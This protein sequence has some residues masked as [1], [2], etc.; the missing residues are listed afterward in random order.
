MAMPNKKKLNKWKDTSLRHKFHVVRKA[1][2]RIILY[3]VLF[4]LAFVFLYPFIKMITTALKSD[5]DIQN[6]TIKWIP[7]SLDWSSFVSAF[8]M[9]KYPK[10]FMN[11]FLVTGFATI[12]HILGC[13]FIGYGFARYKFRGKGLLF[14]GVILSMLIPEQLLSSS[15][16]I[17]FSRVG[18][19]DTYLPFIVPAFLGFGLKGG[20]FV[21]LFR[22]FFIGMPYEMEEAARI[23]GCGPL[24]IFGWIMVPMARS[25]ILVA[26][27]LS[28]VWHW[29]EYYAPRVYM[30]SQTKMFLSSRLPAMYEAL[31]KLTSEVEEVT[32]EAGAIV[33]EPQCMAAT[34]LVIVPL[35][36]I[37]IFAQKKFM[38]GIER[39]GLT[40][41]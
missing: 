37:F 33:S 22:Q 14:A 17:M 21:F 8:K 1:A 13:A 4:D 28:I 7:S 23:D 15:L 2:F 34:F 29:N 39:S 16:Y 40:G 41:M 20:F 31:N 11:S 18:W 6:I 26:G 35:L 10:Y 3:L 38:E 27:I 25:A 12:G 36:I 5:A 24:R 30:K 19:L 32:N 9:L